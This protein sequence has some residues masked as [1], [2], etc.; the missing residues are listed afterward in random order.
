MDSPIADM[1][2]QG[3]SIKAD[4]TIQHD[5]GIEDS[6]VAV[7]QTFQASKVESPR[8]GDDWSIAPPRP[9]FRGDGG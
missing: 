8:L 5:D 6:E 4:A 1:I 7:H 9:P 2:Q 3:T